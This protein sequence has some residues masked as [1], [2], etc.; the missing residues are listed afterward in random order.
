M[1]LRTRADAPPRPTRLAV[2]RAAGEAAAYRSGESSVAG[3]HPADWPID[4]LGLSAR[5]R[6]SLRRADVTTVWQLLTHSRGDLL[7]IQGFGLKCYRD[8][9]TALQAN[10]LPS[11]RVRPKEE[12]R[13]SRAEADRARDELRMTRRMLRSMA[14]AVAAWH[15][16]HFKSPSGLPVRCDVC[17]ELTEAQTLV[18]SV[19]NGSS[20]IPSTF[21]RRDP[22]AQTIRP[23]RGVDVQS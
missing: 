14:R 20:G 12:E 19:P 11:P 22:E 17:E 5:A 4:D 1:S 8:V 9:S 10:R 21:E 16:P 23:E 7:A 15:A 2:R 6:N 18:A 13:S 3:R